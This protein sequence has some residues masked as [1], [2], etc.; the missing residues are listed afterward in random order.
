M[1]C[2]ASPYMGDGARIGA[3]SKRNDLL[4]IEISRVAPEPIYSA[5]MSALLLPLQLLLPM[6]AGWVNRHQLD[7]IEYLQE[8]NRV[9]KERMGRRRIHR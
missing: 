8:E 7:V 2:K 1:H 3:A 5:A 6:F 9:L 4:A